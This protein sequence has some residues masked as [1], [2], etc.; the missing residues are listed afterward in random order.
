VRESG[1]ALDREEHTTGI[2]AAGFAVVVP[3]DGYA[4]ITV[5]M[6]SQ[7]FEGRERQLRAR[8]ATA[9]GEVDAALRPPA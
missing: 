8:L 7:R 1:I 3:D 4:A 9:A 5:P 6:P 2:C